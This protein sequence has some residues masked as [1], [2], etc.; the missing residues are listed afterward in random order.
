MQ[1]LFS[2]LKL[3]VDE[4]SKERA[5]KKAKKTKDSP[6]KATKGQKKQKGSAKEEVDS[7]EGGG[8]DELEES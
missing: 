7:D 6:S 4:H 3:A 8:E 5:D 2:D 1:E